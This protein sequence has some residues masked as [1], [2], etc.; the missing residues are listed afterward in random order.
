MNEE[1]IIKEF[2]E[3][4]GDVGR[5][6]VIHDNHTGRETCVWCGHPTH[7]DI[8]FKE[9]EQYWL[10]VLAVEIKKAE[11]RGRNEAVDFILAHSITMQHPFEHMHE[12][13]IGVLNESRK[14]L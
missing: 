1:K 12:V 8:V 6:P 4:F 2:R 10:S 5:A 11:E 3:K 13:N 7:A 9:L 14:P